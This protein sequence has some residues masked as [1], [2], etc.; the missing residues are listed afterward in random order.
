MEQGAVGLFENSSNE[1]AD[2]RRISQ[3]NSFGF[4][5][6]FMSFAGWNCLKLWEMDLEENNKVLY[7]FP[8]KSSPDVQ[9]L[10][11]GLNPAMRDLKQFFLS[12]SSVWVCG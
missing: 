4:G 3:K 1:T 10:H 6:D 11:M 8:S 2:E 7:C 5:A 12:V 9:S